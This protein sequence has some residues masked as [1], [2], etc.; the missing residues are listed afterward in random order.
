LTGKGKRC[1]KKNP[2]RVP[3]GE[4]TDDALTY[5]ASRSSATTS[6]IVHLFL[7]IFHNL[8]IDDLL[9]VDKEVKFITTKRTAWAA[10][11]P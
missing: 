3:Q 5:L 4:K 11:L 1:E 8:A 6:P 2:R 7:L 10:W 9:S